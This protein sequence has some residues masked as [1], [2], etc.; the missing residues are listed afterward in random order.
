[1]IS[2]HIMPPNCFKIT[3]KKVEPPFSR[4]LEKEFEYIC[5]CLGFFEEIDKEKT[6]SAIFK[7]IVK[8]YE[9][10]KPLT[11]TQIS[12][13]VGM[14]RGAVINHLNNLITAGLIVRQGRYY[15]PRSK[16]MFR[17]IR[18]V[19]EDID[20]IF[21]KMERIAKKIDKEFGIETGESEY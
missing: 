13:K 19:E 6:A 7:E 12:R 4:D 18:E 1:M 20:R 14:S 9:K 3:I 8:S 16:S 10:N 2:F 17:T 11:S 5:K 21:N 15:V